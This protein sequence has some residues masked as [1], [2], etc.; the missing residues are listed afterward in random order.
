MV[1]DYADEELRLTTLVR[2]ATGCSTDELLM[3]LRWLADFYLENDQL[4][5]AE[6]VLKEGLALARTESQSIQGYRSKMLADLATI[7]QAR[8]QRAQAIKAM[9]ESVKLERGQPEPRPLILANRLVQLGHLLAKE[10]GDKESRELF[11]EALT[12]LPMTGPEPH[13]ITAD[14]RFKTIS[15]AMEGLGEL[16]EAIS[17]RAIAVDLVRAMC[18]TDETNDLHL[19]VSSEHTARVIKRDLAEELCSLGSLYIKKGV[20]DFARS[21]L[22]EALE[23]QNALLPPD[24]SKR[25]WCMDTLA[26]LPREPSSPMPSS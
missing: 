7:H 11:L 17:Y 23:L 21:T 6:P 2:S 18:A 24:H 14:L 10:S 3:H 9:S 20:L 5:E 8:C 22:R 15:S 13:E 26:S 16:D 25:T 4:D 1:S 19:S 12:L